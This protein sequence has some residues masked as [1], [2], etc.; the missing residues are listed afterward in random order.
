MHLSRAL[1]SNS[2]EQSSLLTPGTPTQTNEVVVVGKSRGNGALYV[3]WRHLLAPF[4]EGVGLLEF[5]ARSVLVSPRLTLFPLFGVPDT[6]Q[7][8]VCGGESRGTR[9]FYG[10]KHHLCDRVTEGDL[11]S[12]AVTEHCCPTAVNRCGALCCPDFPLP[13]R[14]NRSAQYSDKPVCF[15]VFSQI[16]RKDTKNIPNLQA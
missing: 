4:A 15:R 16:A 2:D 6:N 3:A 9:R 14:N 1:P 7:Q 8:S 5:A 12:V 13:A 10:A 11:V